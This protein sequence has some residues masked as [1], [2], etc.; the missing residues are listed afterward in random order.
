M[1]TRIII[2]LFIILSQSALNAQNNGWKNGIKKD[3]LKVANFEYIM[4]IGGLQMDEAFYIDCEP[5]SRLTRLVSRSADNRFLSVVEVLASPLSSPK[6]FSD[7]TED[8]RNIYYSCKIIEHLINIVWE[9]DKS[10][11]DKIS[12]KDLQEIISVE[13]YTEEIFNSD[14]VIRYV[15]PLK[16]LFTKDNVEYTKGEV[17]I[18]Y[19][20]N[21]GP[22]FFYC[23]YTDEGYENRDVYMKKLE[24]SM[25]LK[26]SPYNSVSSIKSVPLNELKIPQKS[27]Y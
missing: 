25:K 2:L 26:Q 13:H 1:K 15:L 20:N 11:W 27:L 5:N 10:C 3:I 7:Y 12:M 9:Y 22:I 16:E 18:L 19:K 6:I 21:M 8:M 14:T 17:L 24:K 4:D 23:F